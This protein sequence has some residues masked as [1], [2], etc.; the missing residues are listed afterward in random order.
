[1]VEQSGNLFEKLETK[2]I[3]HIAET[4]L[5]K[6]RRKTSGKITENEIAQLLKEDVMALSILYNH[7]PEEVDNRMF[8]EIGPRA[9]YVSHYML[10]NI[11]K[12][13]Q[14]VDQYQSLFLH[15]FH[16]QQQVKILDLGCG[17]GSSSLG[18]KQWIIKSGEA[19]RGQ[20]FRFTG[21]DQ[22]KPFLKD[23][24]QLFIDA[25]PRFSLKTV[26]DRVQPHGRLKISR[27]EKYSVIFLSNFINE[28]KSRDKMFWLDFYHKLIDQYLDDQG[29]IVFMEPALKKTSKALMQLREDLS[30]IYHTIGPCLHQKICPF[31][32]KAYQREW[33]H[34]ESNYTESQLVKVLDRLT[35][36]DHR[37]LKYSYWLATKKSLYDELVNKGVL[38]RKPEIVRVVSNRINL[39]KGCKQ[40][41]CSIDGLQE[42]R[43][44]PKSLKTR[45]LLAEYPPK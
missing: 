20:T 28:L 30:D 44:P 14:L 11:A 9:A 42:I 45:G 12:T 18:L 22:C 35:G 3:G 1:M 36:L 31:L 6:R 33:C 34:N 16:G 21:V 13:Y 5:R 19:L 17:P 40:F 39:N 2:I 10:L 29:I 43:N 7:R 23:F 37:T 26:H 41:I 24:R 8:Q 32:D 38:Q 25:D 15:L 27:E 4:Y